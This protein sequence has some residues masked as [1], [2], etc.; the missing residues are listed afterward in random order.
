MGEFYKTY[1]DSDVQGIRPGSKIF[2]CLSCNSHIASQTDCVSKAFQGRHGRAY[3]FANAYN[4]HL[5]TQEDRELMTGTHT[6]ADIFCNICGESLGWK[7]LKAFDEAQKYK[8][9]RYIVEV[10]TLA[11]IQPCIP[12][13]VIVV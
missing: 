8:E 9:G 3:L 1:L 10:R 7:Y 12:P 5:G 2:T 6:V 11:C 4:V 13:H